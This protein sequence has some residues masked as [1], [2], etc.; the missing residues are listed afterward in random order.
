VV[1]ENEEPPAC[2]ARKEEVSSCDCKDSGMEQRT[3]KER[4]R[5]KD[6]KSYEPGGAE[7]REKCPSIGKT[8]IKQQTTEMEKNRRIWRFL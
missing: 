3:R 2:D 5:A 8:T 4:L 6:E 1:R 7:N